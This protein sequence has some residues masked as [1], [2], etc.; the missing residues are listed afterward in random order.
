MSESHPRLLFVD[1]ED[2]LRFTI[3]AILRAEG[4][5][6]TAAATAAEALRLIANQA[7]DVLLSH[8][9][10]GELSDG[11]TVVS[12]M[13]RSQPNCRTLILT[14][15]PD[16]D[17]ALENIRRQA[18]GYILKPTRPRALAETI[19]KRLATPN[20]NHTG[21]HKSLAQLIHHHKDTI[22]YRWLADVRSD[23]ELQNIAMTDQE[24]IDHLPAVLDEVINALE[25]DKPLVQSQH[26]LRSQ[27]SHV[28]Q[29][30]GAVRKRQGYTLELTFKEARILQCQLFELAQENLLDLD[31]SNIIPDMTVIT[32]TIELLVAESIKSFVSEDVAALR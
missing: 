26:H 23:E 28:A 31:M 29:V 10:I 27:A 5:E 21:F 11:F 13:K 12:A 1:D 14:G 2:S 32:D 9:N 4:F 22:I 24:R 30:H 15:F 3:P 20:H 7:F 8:L 17:N 6:V 25:T 19:R 18:D 16:F